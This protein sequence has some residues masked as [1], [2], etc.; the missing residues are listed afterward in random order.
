MTVIL[1]LLLEF[2]TNIA[3]KDTYH[4]LRGPLFGGF[5]SLGGFILASLVFLSSRLHEFMKSPSE[6]VRRAAV[7]AVEPGRPHTGALRARA[8]QTRWAVN[9]CFL[10]AAI[11]ITV[12]VIE[13]PWARQASV[14]VALLSL[15]YV[16]LTINGALRMYYASLNEYDTDLAEEAR[17]LSE[18][19]K[20]RFLRLL[21]DGKENGAD[22]RNSA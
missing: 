11:Q 7:E 17:A 13:A 8:T 9:A 10:T 14:L 2:L 3:D 20:K 15:A 4:A 6:A 22:N 18:A 5:L 12:G 19:S 16:V 1:D 21:D